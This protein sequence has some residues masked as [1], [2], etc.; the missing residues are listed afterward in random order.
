MKYLLPF[1]Y[2]IVS[3]LFVSCG[4]RVVPDTPPP[5]LALSI[6]Q[7]EFG[8][9]GG[10]MV[11]VRQDEGGLKIADV[12]DIT[13]G[14]TPTI[15]DDGQHAECPGISLDVININTLSVS[16][17]PSTGGHQWAVNLLGP[18][19]VEGDL[20]YYRGNVKVIQAIAK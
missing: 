19:T 20:L 10:E 18:V 11:T 8:P 12:I 13:G 17:E 16:V 14:A 3:L 2:A 15:S 4:N 1:L 5:M 6:Y 9:E 7:I